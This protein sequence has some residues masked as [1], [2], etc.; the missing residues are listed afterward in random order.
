[1]LLAAFNE[2]AGPVQNHSYSHLP[3]SK[4]PRVTPSVHALQ[5]SMHLQSHWHS[6]SLQPL[7]MPLSGRD[8]QKAS[9]VHTSQGQLWEDL[10]HLGMKKSVHKMRHER[11][12][13]SPGCVRK[14]GIFNDYVCLVVDQLFYLSFGFC[15][16][17]FV[18]SETELGSLM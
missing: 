12:K 10:G 8:L 7:P 16:F 17:C 9:L 15:Y 13:C 6:N 4:C 11:V 18:L 3:F 5:V 14:G 1:M 2:V